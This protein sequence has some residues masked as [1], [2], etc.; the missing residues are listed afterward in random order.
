M[1]LKITD[2]RTLQ[3]NLDAAGRIAERR[4]PANRRNRAETILESRNAKPM[5]SYQQVQRKGTPH[6]KTK[7]RTDK[8][9]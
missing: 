5:P 8:G 4:S 9:T 3:D 6:A 1:R 7:Q 2:T